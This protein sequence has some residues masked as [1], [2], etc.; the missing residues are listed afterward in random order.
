MATTHYIGDIE[1][2][3]PSGRTARDPKNQKALDKYWKDRGHYTSP[4]NSGRSDIPT[5]KSGRLA[6]AAKLVMGGKSAFLPFRFKLIAVLFLIL[7]IVLVV[8]MIYINNA[9]ADEEF[10]SM[11]L[12]TNANYTRSTSRQ[13]FRQEL[14]NRGILEAQTI[15][16]LSELDKSDNVI[17]T[18]ELEQTADAIEA[19]VTEIPASSYTG[20]VNPKYFPDE[21]YQEINNY[22]LAYCT[23]MCG[24]YQIGGYKGNGLLYMAM[25]NSESHVWARNVNK[26]TSSVFPSRLIDI[27]INNYK[28]RITNLNFTSVFSL[29][30]PVDGYF[31][32]SS[33]AP[34]GHDYETQGF[35]TQAF[36]PEWIGKAGLGDSANEYDQLM[37]ME[38]AFKTKWKDQ[39]GTL[40]KKISDTCTGGPVSRGAFTEYQVNNV[41]YTKEYDDTTSKTVAEVGDRFNIQDSC[42]AFSYNAN[43]LLTYF[44]GSNAPEGVSAEDIDTPYEVV[45]LSRLGHWTPSLNL[46]NNYQQFGWKNEYDWYGYI[47]AFE[48]PT[49]IQMIKDALNEKFEEGDFRC[50]LS[51]SEL[52]DIQA[53]LIKVGV[54]PTTNKPL[55]QT[56]GQAF[57]EFIKMVAHYIGLEMI[58]SG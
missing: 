50:E 16:A 20:S 4:A 29:S 23:T 49:V 46:V 11:A 55:G 25:A 8:V 10:I 18:E 48:D 27:N 7:A 19:A 31:S 47:Y 57:R 52:D 1:V 9:Y 56:T 30:A 53:Q 42:K 51:A 33:F 14:Y 17:P 3:G 35:L 37:A 24:N 22:L 41:W 38:D 44:Y 36:Y 2:T 12:D 34:W 5:S 45:A 15:K 13:V 54:N 58:Y 6:T 21:D 28:E 26:T 40:F 32:Y 43:N 39:D